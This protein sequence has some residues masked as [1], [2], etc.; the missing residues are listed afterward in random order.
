MGVGRRAVLCCWI[1]AATVVAPVAA[2][3]AS[4]EPR[5]TEAL[6]SASMLASVNRA[7]ARHGLGP[8]LASHSLSRSAT[9]YA[10]YMLKH[11]YFGHQRRIRA[12]RRYHTLGEAL[13]I[14]RGWRARIGS[15]VNQWMHSPGHRALIL[16]HR[17]RY[18]GAGKSRGR[19]GRGRATTWVLH[20]GA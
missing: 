6:A 9:R 5:A 15:T 20:F 4:P 17:F 13:A 7:R 11:D 12:S 16:S 2:E 19:Y 10:A 3:A 1:A 18:L 8:L 14:H